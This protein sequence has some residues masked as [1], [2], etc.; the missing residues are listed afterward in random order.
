M[1]KR[2]DAVG[3]VI[4]GA[5]APA[6]LFRLVSNSA[7]EMADYRAGREREKP[8]TAIAERKPV[9]PR[10]TVTPQRKIAEAKESIRARPPSREPPPNRLTGEP[11]SHPPFDHELWS[12]EE[13]E[14]GEPWRW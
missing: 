4:A 1:G 8:H 13:D 12:D 7:N 10:N 11:P 2:R 3:D 9:A 14:F 6:D 5:G